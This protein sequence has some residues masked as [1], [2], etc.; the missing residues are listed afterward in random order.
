VRNRTSQ[1]GQQGV[2]LGTV[3]AVMQNLQDLLKQAAAPSSRTDV[4]PG[5]GRWDPRDSGE[6]ALRARMESCH[7]SKQGC[8]GLREA[9]ERADGLSTM[10]HLGSAP[11]SNVTQEVLW[12]SPE[13]AQE[14]SGMTAWKLIDQLCISTMNPDRW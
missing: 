6:P 7:H 13:S 4:T 3:G 10:L 1:E 9:G 5:D 14:Q 2:R 11:P 12:P 8:T